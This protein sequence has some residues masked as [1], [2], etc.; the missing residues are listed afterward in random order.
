[1][2]PLFSIAPEGQ[3]TKDAFAALG[4]DQE[5]EHVEQNSSREED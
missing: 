1:M 3:A 2:T 5:E 4:Y